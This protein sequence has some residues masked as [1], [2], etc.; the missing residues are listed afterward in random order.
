M[1]P[2]KLLAGTGESDP[3]AMAMGRAQTAVAQNT[4]AYMWNPANLGLDLANKN[5]MTI[6]AFAVG[7]RIGNNLLGISDYNYYNG[8]VFTANDKA[9]F[10]DLF[11][12][13]KSLSGSVDGEA[14]ALGIQYQ[15]Y[16]VNFEFSGGGF[17]EVPKEIFDVVLSPSAY[18]L[19]G[20][21]IKAR[22][23]GSGNALLTIA[24]SGGFPIKNFLPNLFHEFS[25]GASVKYIHGYSQ[26]TM[27]DLSASVEQGDSLIVH[28]RYAGRQSDGGTGVGF[29]FGVA[30]QINK[31]WSAGLSVQNI[32]S[33]IKWKS[34]S[35][36]H[37]A[38][39][40]VRSEDLFEATKKKNQTS[41]D[42]T[43]RG[44][45]YTTTL[46]SIL[47]AGA[48]Y[49]MDK[50]TL[51]AFDYEQFLDHQKGKTHPRL[52]AG[53]EFRTWEHVCLRTGMS[54]GGDNRGFNIAGGVGFIL[55][56]TA[57]DVAT[58]NLEGLIILRRFSF[59]LSVKVAI[60]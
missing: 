17:I 51:F 1:A 6:S 10:L 8:R 15:N 34:N 54:V 25:V 48:A 40:A 47:H 29:N 3:R 49:Q 32:Y 55:G 31:R 24:A 36:I 7:F 53:A 44:R 46:P 30:A 43:Y 57:I 18:V 39:F 9:K 38:D 56:K 33:Q 28:A 14:R 4:E 37:E 23:D 60:Q 19:G 35:K 52:A 16:A 45:A 21:S 58:N 22:G 42:T 20:Q 41:S 2:G 59:A 13:D 11:G 12:S 5:K 50:K 26:V 27:K